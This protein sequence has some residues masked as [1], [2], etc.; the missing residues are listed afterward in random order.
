MTSIGDWGEIMDEVDAERFV[1]REQELDF[2]KHQMIRW[3]GL[4]QAQTHIDIA[5]S[6][7]LTS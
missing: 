3:K 1:G 2:F 6:F 4:S 7:L 5:R